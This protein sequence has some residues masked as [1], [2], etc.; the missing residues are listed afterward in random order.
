MVLT[1]MAASVIAAY[2]TQITESMRDATEDLQ[3]FLGASCP[4]WRVG[5][6]RK[7]AGV[8]GLLPSDRLLGQL[9]VSCYFL[10][11]QVWQGGHLGVSG[12]SE[13]CGIPRL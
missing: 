3:V 6:H 1:N 2:P 10:G 4:I 7:L 8:P 5:S 13:P 9:A 11:Y 12:A